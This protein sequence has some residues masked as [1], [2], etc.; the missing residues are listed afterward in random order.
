MTLPV[1]AAGELAKAI[2]ETARFGSKA[3]DLA[4][5]VGGYF[6]R[7]FGTLPDNIVGLLGADWIEYKR[8]ENLAKLYKRAEAIREQLGTA[9]PQE[10]PLS[11]GLPLM[12][13]AADENREEL[14]DLWARLLAS[15]M[16]PV[17]SQ[18]VR[19]SFVDIVQRLDPLDVRVFDA[20]FDGADLSPSV[21]RFFAAHFKVNEDSVQ[22]SLDNLNEVGLIT[23]NPANSNP[24]VWLTPKGREFKR[25]LP[26][27]P[28]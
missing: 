13:A 11:L 24:H 4:R 16:D 6:A 21:A 8:L 15:A 7:V 14:L 1:P 9:G 22:V 17:R 3:L 25:A 20:S 19:R 18:F 28:G 27:K 26:P 12:R 10:V 5:D 2:Q 23:Y